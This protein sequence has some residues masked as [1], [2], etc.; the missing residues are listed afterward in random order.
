MPEGVTYLKI[1]N[2]DK[3][4]T[5]RSNFIRQLETLRIVYNAD[6][7][8]EYKI[9]NIQFQENSYW[10]AVSLVSQ[11]SVLEDYSVLD[12][13]LNLDPSSTTSSF[14][15]IGGNKYFT[16]SYGVTGNPLNYFNATT[17]VYT[18]GS[19][20]NVRLKVD[21]DIAITYL[22]TLPTDAS[23]SLALID[24]ASFASGVISS[25]NYVI[26]D[27]Q[28]INNITNNETLTLYWDQNSPIFQKGRKVI[29]VIIISDTTPA[30]IGTFNWTE[31]IIAM[32]DNAGD[33][34]N[35]SSNGND[36]LTLF[37]PDGAN[38]DYNDFNPLFNNAEISR[39]STQFLDVDY[40]SGLTTPLNFIPIILGTAVH[41]PV[42]DSNYASKA[43]SNPRYNGVRS[44]SNG[45]NQNL[46][47]G[48]F[49]NIPNVEQ[50]Q[51][52]F[53][54]FETV[55]NTAP[56]IKNQTAY[57]V[58][59][60]VDS[61]GEVYQPAPLTPTLYNLID[62]F[63]TNK[64]ATLKTITNSGSNLAFLNDTHPITNVGR[65]D[66][67]LVSET[68]SGKEDYAQTMSFD[69]G[70]IENGTANYT[71]FATATSSIEK[72]AAGVTE[73]F[74]SFSNAAYNTTGSN[75]SITTNT[76]T[77]TN[78]GTTTAATGSR[79]K[80]NTSILLYSD[81]NPQFKIQFIKGASDVI[82]ETV[83]TA[84]DSLAPPPSQQ[85]SIAYNQIG[86]I[87]QPT[88][89]K[90]VTFSTPFLDFDTSNTVRVK[91]VNLDTNY[92][93]ATR[94]GSS[95]SLTQ[96][97]SPSARNVTSSASTP[98]WS[99]GSNS[100]ATI[101]T[102]SSGLTSVYSIGYKQSTPP[103][104]SIFG[105]PTINT[106]FDNLQI[107]DKIRFEYL[108]EKKYNISEIIPNG[109]GGNLCLKLD[110]TIPTGT[111]LNHFILYRVVNDG[112]SIILDI[113][114]TIPGEIFTGIIQPEYISSDVSNNYN[115]IIKSLTEKGLIS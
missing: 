72:P 68:G 32:V 44:T 103:S 60:L 77:F 21:A 18:L 75:Y 115:E 93:I 14:K 3:N 48:G 86:G 108:E 81:G 40:E 58:K 13:T 114:K 76:Y 70:V 47:F 92:R 54:Y 57:N 33:T 109:P 23:A 7:V 112:S 111:Q 71:F 27:P 87:F 110:G 46:D 94:A 107:G 59:Y 29:P 10:C 53:A 104:S 65:L 89:F 113:N 83:E 45:F 8:K 16:A 43:W 31:L 35:A 98:Y 52:F 95:F 39:L 105:F 96:E 24:S 12:Y 30:V 34:V 85:Q 55:Q 41:A 78:P 97:Y 80:F 49:G 36:K 51:T 28:S 19:L 6:D 88:K 64:K 20:P 91:I 82:A 4:G 56:I 37:E 69:F 15:T 67:I 84:W 101:L 102:A 25:D 99:T 61:N 26:S 63:E 22:S 106:T 90:T 62:S 17:G 9:R 5:D 73:A 11:S 100:G 1:S 66:L 79:V 2:L 38:W 74:V 42:Q 50:N